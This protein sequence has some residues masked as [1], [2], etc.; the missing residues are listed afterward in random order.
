[1]QDDWLETFYVLD[2]DDLNLGQTKPAVLS[3]I[4][5]RSAGLDEVLD[6]KEMENADEA[7]R[8]SRETVLG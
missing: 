4:S 5:I 1:M 3:E 6:S 8:G 2:M 7:C